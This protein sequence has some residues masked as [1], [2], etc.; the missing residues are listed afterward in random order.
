[1]VKK[2]ITNCQIETTIVVCCQCEQRPAQ[3]KL[4]KDGRRLAR[5]QSL[6]P[7]PGSP[8]AHVQGRHPA[9][10]RLCVHKY[11]NSAHIDIQGRHPARLRFCTNT[12]TAMLHTYKVDTLVVSDSVQ[13][14]Q[15]CTRTR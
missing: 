5:F 11:G 10:L 1:M 9:R 4:H 8:A 13:I 6:H 14:Q 7:F 3:N 15:C 2:Y 12:E